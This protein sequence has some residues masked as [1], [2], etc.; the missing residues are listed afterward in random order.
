MLK[1]V[2]WTLRIQNVYI[3]HYT[4]IDPTVNNGP[5]ISC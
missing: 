4:D 1:Y 2:S 5:R 3:N